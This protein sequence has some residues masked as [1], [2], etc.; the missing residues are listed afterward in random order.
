MIPNAT[1]RLA[2]GLAIDPLAQAR[3][4]TYPAYD[5]AIKNLKHVRLERPINAE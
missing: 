5:C 1:A 3:K 2:A 4:Q